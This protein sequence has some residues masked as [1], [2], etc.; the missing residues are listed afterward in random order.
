MQKIKNKLQSR[1]RADEFTFFQAR[2]P[3]D[4]PLSRRGQI[5]MGFVLIG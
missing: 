2:K 5:E 1:F 3:L 4:G